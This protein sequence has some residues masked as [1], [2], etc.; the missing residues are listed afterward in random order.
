MC[1]ALPWVV[2]A[3]VWS[4]C[5]FDRAMRPSVANSSESGNSSQGSGNSSA[6]SN[7]SSANSN[8]SSANS[9]NSSQGTSNNSQ[10]SSNSNESSRNSSNG[11]TNDNA[12]RSAVVMAGSAL[13]IAAGVGIG[14]TIYSARR[15]VQPA[16]PQKLQEDAQAA[17]AWLRANLKQLKQDL[18]LGAGPTLDDLACAAEIRLE[19][20]TRFSRLLHR[21]RGELLSPLSDAQ[22][23]LQQ[24]LSVMTRVG[25]LAVADEVLRH[26][27]DAFSRKHFGG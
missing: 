27:A 9:N 1:K 11:T 23:S 2:L 8:N 14:L 7:N 20:R 3:A 4:G 16:E 25:E 15:N 18:A 10:D 5:V 24:A 13:L 26:D 21:H 17:Q 22:L 19:N 6:N 12:Q